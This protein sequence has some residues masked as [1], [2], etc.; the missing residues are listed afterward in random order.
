MDCC[1]EQETAA[2]QAQKVPVAAQPE[3]PISTALTPVLE[4]ADRFSPAPPRSYASVELY[5]LHSTFL[6]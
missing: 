2:P 6:I 4:P 5:A 1:Q 3:P